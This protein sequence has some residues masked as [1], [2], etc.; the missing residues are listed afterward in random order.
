MSTRF[1]NIAVFSVVLTVVGCTGP[2][3]FDASSAAIDVE[4]R[5]DTPIVIDYQ[6]TGGIAG[7]Q[8][9]LTVYDNQLVR[10][11]DGH[12][13]QQRSFRD[14]LDK[15][16]YESLIGTFVS[17]NFFGL[18]DRY[19]DPQVVDGFHHLI[20]FSHGNRSKTV[21]AVDGALPQQL[22]DIITAL[23]SAMDSLVRDGIRLTLTLSDSTI[24]GGDSVTFTLTVTAP[25]HTQ[26][27]LVFR[28]GQIY[29]FFV[30]SDPPP[31]EDPLP[32]DRIVWRWSADKAF[33][34]VIW[35]MTL[36]PGESRTYSESW[37][38]RDAEG[39]PLKGRFWV[40]GSLVSVPGGDSRPVEL[41]VE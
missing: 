8:R 30:V 29:D 7:I 13:V 31:S 3:L 34:Q 5:A 14:R 35:K 27:S 1:L 9:R 16:R 19:L 20:T 21:E 12:G 11:K 2:N 24:A 18:K 41:V 36:A 10:L 4:F 39:N 22:Q 25:S 33:T 17:A 15:A 26:R 37:T 38:A 23:N 40:I 32:E 6:I 28:S